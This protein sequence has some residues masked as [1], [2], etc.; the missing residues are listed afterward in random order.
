MSA[1]PLVYCLEQLTDYD[2]FERLC[3]DLMVLEGFN[4]LEPIGGTKDRGRDAIHAASSTV[5]AYSVREDWRK[6]LDQDSAK[7]K[8]HGHAC[9]RL[10][11]LCTAG[12]TP[13]ERDDAVA[14]I[15]STYGW[16]LDIYGLER[17]AMLLRTTHRSLVAQHP[18]I[19][20]PP[21]FP[22]AGG[23]SLSLALD[24]LILDHLD[25]DAP[26]AH[27]LARRLSLAGFNVWCRGLAPLAGSSAGETI[28]ALLG[29]RAFRY[30]C[31]L[32]PDAVSDPEL[33]GRLQ[34]AHAMG[35]QRGHSLVIPATAR[36]FPQEAL[37]LQTRSLVPAR[38]DESWATGL[39]EVEAVLAAA[40]CPRQPTGARDLVVRSY[41]PAECITVSPEVLASNLFRVTELPKAIVRYLSK[42]P[43]EIDG[44]AIDDSPGAS[45]WAFR[46]INARQ[47]LSFVPPPA[48]F[49][50]QFEM[51]AKGGTALSSLEID[52]VRVRDLVPEL[53]RKSL[54]SE[55]RRRGLCYFEQRRLIYFPPGLLKNEF[56]SFSTLTGET[57]RFAVTG[58]RKHGY[59]PRA[60]SYRYHVAPVFAPSRQEGD[61]GYQVILRI[62]VHLTNLLGHPF[63][64]HTGAA[65]RKKLCRSWWNAEWLNRTLGV[66]QFLASGQSSVV[67][68]EPTSSRLVIDSR[69][70]CWVAPLAL[71]EEALVPQEVAAE[72]MSWIQ[73]DEDE[74]EDVPESGSE[75]QTQVPA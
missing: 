60:S 15:Q 72:E 41:F 18:A 20:C 73:D 30:I 33:L 16:S 71:N 31:V 3:H 56:I 12:F 58:E 63:P 6:K 75:A 28:R 10:I 26:V 65:R 40:H 69:P 59:G 68:G 25:V 24:H 43:L 9:A 5:F 11:F 14:D 42:R 51:R 48:A 19:F 7:V 46:R 39:R 29:S 70:R 62:R 35:V 57:S 22:R 23:L 32:S 37:D 27:W 47:F 2:Q 34:F 50:E 52:G 44:H 38:F 54:Y 66:M 8:D 74:D 21:F 64:G 13:T 45:E 36:P 55:C 17:I 49:V 53:I 1:D 4:G 67:I 61:A